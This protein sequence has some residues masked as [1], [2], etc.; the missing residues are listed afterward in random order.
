MI[1]RIM[2]IFFSFSSLFTQFRAGKTR[3]YRGILSLSYRWGSKDRQE[4]SMNK[5][6]RLRNKMLE[7]VATQRKVQ[8]RERIQF[9]SDNFL[10]HSDH[11]KNQ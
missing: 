5:S 4:K 6:E 7:L 9:L 1:N 2:S 8:I 10:N 11:G 3:N